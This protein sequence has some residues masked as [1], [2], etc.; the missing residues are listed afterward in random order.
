ML[1][2]KTDAVLNLLVKK[3][4][5]GYSVLNKEQLLSELP[6]KFHLEI[7]ALLNIINFLKEDEYIDVKYQD[8]DEI[9]LAVTVKAT[10]YR[11]GE[12][13][14]VQRAHITGGQVGLLLLGVF[15]AAFVGALVATLIGKLF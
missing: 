12:K 15:F 13:N 9:C 8:K 2:K 1:D 6:S 4:G 5:D 3:A 7:Q 14:V 11:E 10:S